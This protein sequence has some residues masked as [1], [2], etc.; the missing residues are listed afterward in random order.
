MVTVRLLIVVVPLVKAANV[1]APETPSV[2]VRVELVVTARE[3]T[4]VA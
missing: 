2:P 1:V 3:L 4:V